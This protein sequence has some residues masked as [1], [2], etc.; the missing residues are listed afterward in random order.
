MTKKAF[1]LL[2]FSF[3]FSLHVL[4]K[5]LGKIMR[6]KMFKEKSLHL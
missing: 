6:L 2:L 1:Y 4:Q 5:T 3:F